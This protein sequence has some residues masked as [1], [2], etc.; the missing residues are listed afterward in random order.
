MNGSPVAGLVRG[1][2]SLYTR[3]LPADARAARR[4]EIDDDLWCQHAE[5]AAAGRSAR[6]LHADLFLRLLLGM[7]ADLSWRLTHRRAPTPP[8][9]VSSPMNTRTLGVLA[10]YAGASPALLGILLYAMG[11]AL[12][13]S[14]VALVLTFGAI[15]AFPAAALGL[16]WR[17][18]D[19]IGPLGAI[20]AILVT[21]GLALII[22]APPASVVLPVGSAMLMWDLARIGVLSRRIAIA[23]LVLAI[24][25]IGLGLLRVLLGPGQT[26]IPPVAIGVALY[27]YLLS[28]VAI[29]VSLIRGVPHSQGTSA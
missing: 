2:V 8:S 27:A 3:G 7:P 18:S 13:T 19:H 15:F 21:L 12:W 17:F 20:G 16:A 4:D 23:Q 25:A 24:L 9:K 10:V 26:T 14:G 22:L 5:A 1:W 6:S 11:D 28:W 29:G